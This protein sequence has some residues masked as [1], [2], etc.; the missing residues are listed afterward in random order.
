[1]PSGNRAEILEHLGYEWWMFRSAHALLSEHGAEGDPVRNAL[2]ESLAI[3]GRNLAYFFHEKK[4]PKKDDWNAEDLEIELSPMPQ[5]LRAWCNEVNKRIAHLT[6]KRINAL[7]KWN[8]GAIRPLLEKRIAAVKS[9]LRGD[10]P[11]DWI[12]DR[13]AG[14]RAR[15]TSPLALMTHPSSIAIPLEPLSF[16]EGDAAVSPTGTAKPPEITEAGPK[17]AVGAKGSQ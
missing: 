1:M 2:V 5:E 4:R 16:L 10:T 7:D 12:G 11:A 9:H 8:P 3:H 17:G 15:F 6:A 14:Y 13:G